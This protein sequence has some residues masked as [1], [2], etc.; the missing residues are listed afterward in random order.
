MTVNYDENSFYGIGPDLFSQDEKK[1]L[2][3]EDVNYISGANID[4]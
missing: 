4:K 2:A 1:K 3:I